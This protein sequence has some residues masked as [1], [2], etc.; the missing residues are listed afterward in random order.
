MCWKRHQSIGLPSSKGHRECHKN[1]SVPILCEAKKLFSDISFRCDHV[2][3]ALHVSAKNLQWPLSLK[4]LPLTS[5]TNLCYELMLLT[6]ATNF[7][8]KLLLLTF[9]TS[10]NIQMS[11]WIRTKV[12][13]KLVCFPI[14]FYFI[15]P[16]ARVAKYVGHRHRRSKYISVQDKIIGST[17]Y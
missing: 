7:C 12:D 11:V 15:A 17:R 4:K 10:P 5:A 8:Y 14:Y 9:G 2:T 1:L 3:V 6:F 16:F 13:I